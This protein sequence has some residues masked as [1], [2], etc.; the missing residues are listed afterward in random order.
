MRG[1]HAVAVRFKRRSRGVERLRRPGEV[2]RD[3]R[4][5]GLGDDTPRAGYGLLRAEG[6][7]RASQ[8]SL[9]ANEIAELRHGDAAKGE[10]G[11]IVAQGDPLQGAERITCCKRTR[12]GRDQQV[13]AN[14]ATLV[15]PTVRCL[16]PIFLTITN[17]IVSRTQ[18]MTKRRRTMTTH[19]TGTREEWLKARLELLEAEKELTRKGDELAR[20]RQE[21]PWIRVD[22]PYRFD[23]DAG[24]AS[25][26]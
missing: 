6:A 5:L 4:D 9:C 25:L 8:E 7:H 19:I 2:A 20:R 13:H 12:R 17:H 18:R 16:A 14:P 22:K 11:R 1:V 10:R 15:T 21:L 26:A 3:E 24:H 23:T